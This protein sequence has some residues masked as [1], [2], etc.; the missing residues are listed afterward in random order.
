LDHINIWI[1]YCHSSSSSSIIFFFRDEELGLMDDGMD[2]V[3]FFCF[4]SCSSWLFCGASSTRQK[5]AV[6]YIHPLWMEGWTEGLTGWKKLH[7][8]M[9]TTSFTYINAHHFNHSL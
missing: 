7:F 9:T 1:N 8:I 5:E 6:G 3:S 4:C 2:V